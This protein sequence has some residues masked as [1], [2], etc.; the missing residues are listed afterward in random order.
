MRNNYITASTVL[1]SL[2]IGVTLVPFTVLMARLVEYLLN[3]QFKEWWIT[4]IWVL[5]L[6]LV[7]LLILLS[8][9]E[10]R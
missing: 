5:G 4:L 9:G 2:I 1:I 10:R 8:K 6:L 7:S 3:T